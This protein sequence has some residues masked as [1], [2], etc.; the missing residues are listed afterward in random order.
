[1]IR[2]LLL[3]ILLIG[4]VSASEAQK[5]GTVKLPNDLDPVYHLKIDKYPKFEADIVFKDGR[6]L[7][8]CC[9]KSMMNYFY[10]PNYFPEFGMKPDGSDI[11]KMVVRDYIDGTKVD[12]TKAWYVFG[13]KLT[14][15][16]GD[17]LIPFASHAK[18]ELFVQRFGGSKIMSFETVRNKGFGLIDFL[19]TP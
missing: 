12:A 1:M 15:P 4:G 6:T 13:S 16:H 8:F 17:D 7:R 3:V 18:A 5:E 19:D 9:V 11:A 10:R 2:V 14:G